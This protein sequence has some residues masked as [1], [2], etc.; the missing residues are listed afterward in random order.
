M[1]IRVG[2]MTAA[3]AAG[4]L[5]FSSAPSWA[6]ST[7]HTSSGHHASAM[8]ADHFIKEAAMGRMAEVELGQLAEERGS[9]DQV[10][11]FG[12]RMV[13]D[14]TKVNDDLKTMAA[15]K[16]V[17]LPTDLD[18]KNQA[19]R[20]RLAKL[21]GDEFDRAYMSDMVKD[22]REDVAAFEKATKS[23]DSDVQAF[24]SKNLPTLKEHLSQARQV[25]QQFASRGNMK[26][27]GKDQGMA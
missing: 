15:R 4:L 27:E 13:D 26:Q 16:N 7:K 22:H 10:K 1:S 19:T 5:L 6:K 24:A 14:H 11:A 23:T 21:S 25:E 20:D 17:T 8:R 18:A 3:A 12:K 2:I 9:S